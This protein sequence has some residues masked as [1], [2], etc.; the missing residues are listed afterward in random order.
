MFGYVSICSAVK[1]RLPCHTWMK[2]FF[3]LHKDHP[4]GLWLCHTFVFWAI[5]RW[6]IVALLRN[7][8]T[9]KV[10]TQADGCTLPFRISHS[11]TYSYECVPINYGKSTRSWRCKKAPDNN[12][13]AT[14]DLCFVVALMKCSVSFTAEVPRTLQIN[15]QSC[16]NLTV[17]GLFN[18]C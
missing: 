12:T 17:G 15:F 8:S 4:R 13:T 9:L 6:Q 10:T 14:S 2:H 7:Q 16:E 11:D 1:M 3:I 5:H 18:S